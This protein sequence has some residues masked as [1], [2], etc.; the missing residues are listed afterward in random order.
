ML[1]LGARPGLRTPQHQW[2]L[3]AGGAARESPQ[4]EVSPGVLCTP[5]D[6]AMASASSKVRGDGQAVA[7]ALGLAMLS[8]LLGTSLA[9]HVLLTLLVL[10]ERSLHVSLLPAAAPVPGRRAMRSPASCQSC[11]LG[12]WP[13][14]PRDPAGPS[15]LQAAHLPGWALL[16]PGPLPAARSHPLPGHGPPPLLR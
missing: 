1:L 15:G 12:A 10:W 5:G 8:L 3:S 2:H 9:G 6:T 7:L 16:L 13:Q 14:L 4:V 11:W